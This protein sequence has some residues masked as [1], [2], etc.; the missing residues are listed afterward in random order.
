M[1]AVNLFVYETE[2]KCDTQ[3]RLGARKTTLQLKLS[4]AMLLPY[5]HKPPGSLRNRDVD[6]SRIHKVPH[7][8]GE[9]IR[10]EWFEGFSVQK[11][12]SVQS[13]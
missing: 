7:H 11:N 2:R 1:I 10:M 4:R 5:P 6:F 3:K 9:K 8:R 13:E 12:V